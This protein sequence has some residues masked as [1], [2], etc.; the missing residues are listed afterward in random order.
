M[1]H[2]SL[3]ER[4]AFFQASPARALLL[5][6]LMSD[7][8]AAR[9]REQVRPVL[10][11][12]YLADRGRYHVNDTHVEP[13]LFAGLAAVASETAEVAVKVAWARWMRLVHGDYALYKNDHR[14]WRTLDHHLE[15]VVDF[16]D[17][18]CT[19]AQIVYTT[20]TESF[21]VPQ[22]PRCG[23]LIDRRQPIQRYDRYLSHRMGETEVFRLSLALEVV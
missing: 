3:E 21:W 15:V 19:E 8:A 6:R 16:S 22:Q 4:R 2:L 14:L 23:A 5:E 1:I 11:P 10:R 9:L 7:A 17:G 18:A 12:Y 13:E 20:P